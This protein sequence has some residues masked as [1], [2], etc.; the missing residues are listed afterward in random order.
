MN[1]I[2]DVCCNFFFLYFCLSFCCF[3]FVHT[4][5]MFFPFGPVFLYLSV[6]LYVSSSHVTF[7]WS[8]L[9][10]SFNFRAKCQFVFDFL[11]FCYLCTT[12]AL[13]WTYQIT[14][15]T[16]TIS[17]KLWY[18]HVKTISMCF[19]SLSHALSKPQKLAITHVVFVVKAYSDEKKKYILRLMQSMEN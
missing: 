8:L 2:S 3:P 4:F 6:R 13:M 5:N 7:L 17:S 18:W 10:M 16:N 15:I 19:L 9:R 11:V 1:E 14:F 12:I